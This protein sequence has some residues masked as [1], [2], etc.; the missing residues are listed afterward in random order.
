MKTE[1]THYIECFENVGRGKKRRLFQRCVFLGLVGE[2]RAKVRVLHRVRDGR[3]GD[4]YDLIYMANEIRYVKKDRLI[5][6]YV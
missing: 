1:A 2:D 5:N 4:S 6:M 3:G